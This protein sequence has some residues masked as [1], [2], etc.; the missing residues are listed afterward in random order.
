VFTNTETGVVIDNPPLVD[1]MLRRFDGELP[2]LAYR[3]TL[4]PGGELEWVDSGEDGK[5]VRY[6]R[7]PE[8]G[9]WQ[10]LK[11]WF[12]SLWPLEPLL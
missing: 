8:T 11:A 6:R 10:R 3:V 1:E 4:Q 5:E 2:K 12:Y 7:E 9:A